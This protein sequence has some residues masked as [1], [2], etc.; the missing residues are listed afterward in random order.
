LAFI[1]SLFESLKTVIFAIAIIVLVL[2]LL[3]LFGAKEIEEEK[4][5]S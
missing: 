5:A 1:P 3:R 2:I 4:E